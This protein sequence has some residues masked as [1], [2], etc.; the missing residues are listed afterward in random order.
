MNTSE[1]C[2]LVTS[3]IGDF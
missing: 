3:T 2:K 1:G